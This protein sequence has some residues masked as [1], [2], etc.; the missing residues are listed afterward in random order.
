MRQVLLEPIAAVG[1][2]PTG[3]ADRDGGK[4]GPPKRQRHFC[5][6][7]TDRKRHPED[8]ALHGAI[9]AVEIGTFD[10]RA[11]GWCPVLTFEAK[12]GDEPV[13]VML[14]VTGSFDSD[15]LKQIVG[16]RVH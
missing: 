11:W 14:C 9:V 7:T 5:D 2:P 13:T 1:D 4:E 15:C 10:G 8:F 3:H 16:C 6:E 12:N